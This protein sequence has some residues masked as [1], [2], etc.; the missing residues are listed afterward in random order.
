[1]ETIRDI[2][3]IVFGVTGTV[4]SLIVL[5]LCFKLYGKASHALE[6]VGA[7]AEDVHVVTEQGRK[8]AGLAKG[9]SEILGPTMSPFNLGRIGSRGLAVILG[10]RRITSKRDKSRK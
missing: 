6:Q 9:V 8:L 3:L 1:L 4:T 2:V 5:L 10:I 7:V